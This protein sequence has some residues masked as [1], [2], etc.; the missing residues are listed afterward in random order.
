MNSSIAFIEFIL[1]VFFYPSTESCKPNADGQFTSL[2]LGSASNV[3][4]VVG[5][6]IYFICCGGLRW[7]YEVE[8]D[9]TSREIGP[10]PYASIGSSKSPPDLNFDDNLSP[11]SSS[12]MKDSTNLQN[13]VPTT[14]YTMHDDKGRLILR[15]DNVDVQDMGHYKC[16]GHTTS[17]DAYLVVVDKNYPEE[18]HNKTLPNVGSQTNLSIGWK[19]KVKSWLWREPVLPSS[20]EYAQLPQGRPP[21]RTVT[22]IKPG[23]HEGKHVEIGSD[24]SWA[25]IVDPLSPEAPIKLW[26][27]FTMPF[28]WVNKDPIIAYYEIDWELY[29][30]ISPQ[31]YILPGDKEFNFE[32][33]N[34]NLSKS[35]LSNQQLINQDQH[36]TI[37]HSI[38]AQIDESIKL[39]NLKS[40][41]KSILLENK[42]ARIAC[43]FRS[44]PLT[45]I[46]N[47]QSNSLRI[48][49]VYWYRNGQSVHVPPF[50]VDN[51]LITPYG[52]SILSVRA[53]PTIFNFSQIGDEKSSTVTVV[54]SSDKY[55]LP[56]EHL[57]CSVISRVKETPI[58][59][60]TTNASLQTEIILVPRI[61]HTELLS[62]ERSLEDA[63]KLT[64]TAIANGPP[65]MRI[66][67]ASTDQPSTNNGPTQWESLKSRYGLNI[68]PRQVDPTNPLIHRLV[69]DISVWNQAGEA[70]AIGHV[71]VHS[72]PQLELMSFG[73]NYF[74][75]HKPWKAS[76]VVK[77]YPLA[78]QYTNNS[79]INQHKNREQSIETND[80]II[81]GKQT[82]D[83]D[84]GIRGLGHRDHNQQS[85]SNSVTSSIRMKIFNIEG[86][87]LDR[88]E[89]NQIDYK[90]GKFTGIN[91]TYEIH[92]NQRYGR[93]A[94]V[95]CE[96]THIDNRTIYRETFLRE[97]TKPTAPNITVLCTGPRAIVFGITN[98]KLKPDNMPTER[99]VTQKV[100]F[101]PAKTFHLSST[102]AS[103][104]VYL[105]SEG[106]P[107]I[108]NSISAQPQTA[109]I[110]VKNL[111]PDT[112]YVFEWSSGNEFGLSVMIQFTLWT[113]KLET[114]PTIKNIVF[115]S[116]T[117]QYLRFSTFLGDPCPYEGG[118]RPELS[119]LLVRY[120]LAKS[121][122]TYDPTQL[123][124]YG[125][126]SD[127]EVCKNLASAS[128]LDINYS[129]NNQN[130]NIENF[131]V[132]GTEED[133]YTGI[134]W[135][136][137]NPI[138]CEIPVPDT[139]VIYEIEVATR[140]RFEKSD[141]F[142]TFYR[143][144]AVVSA[145][146]FCYP[147]CSA[148]MCNLSGIF[149]ILIF[150]C[151]FIHYL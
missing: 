68:R 6:D 96:Y 105:D 148:I 142:K 17:L 70:Q 124:G 83:K 33:I 120:R 51:S 39:A 81:T 141:W 78:G 38:N 21:S 60:V 100:I 7:T 107:T 69:I 28:P 77:G 8:D 108:L 145:A 76:C 147:K 84:S 14:V 62:A 80:S 58:Y 135:A 132:V 46:P 118:A 140:N 98:P 15:I 128:T 102:L 97:A 136:G 95:R 73:Y 116:P 61:I 25:R 117:S 9:Y 90:S 67:F 4:A 129:N 115:L 146:L 134:K 47:P 30:P 127:V 139:Q 72:E 112:E 79:Q 3:T 130:D 75:G 91:A 49:N 23:L 27:Q 56:I 151:S 137:D 93:E 29:E 66:D 92:M 19:T 48:Q 55:K 53:Y 89:I 1:L 86:E 35:I 12:N 150:L 85:N 106:Q 103:L 2:E 82:A 88:V 32:E 11:S 13:T 74:L 87:P 40:P 44:I 138:P 41:N 126:W 143:P 104:S 99:I 24:L 133:E 111:I 43:R 52:L 37:A 45:G 65:N 144:N 113:K 31:I 94:I 22:A 101:A 64:C 114:A 125:D 149:I 131:N 50:Y 71:L 20:T 119:D 26:C 63:I 122:S 121:N 123:I 34:Q 110:P 54:G 59:K 18:P 57:T 36:A 10:H 16:H 42:P 109:V 5:S